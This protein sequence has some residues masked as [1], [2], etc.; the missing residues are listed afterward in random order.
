MDTTHN[1]RNHSAKRPQHRRNGPKRPHQK[2]YQSNYSHNQNHVELDHLDEDQRLD[3]RPPRSR[4]VLQ[5]N[6]DK[7]LNLAR[8]AMSAGDRVLSEHNLQHADHFN[9]LLNEQKDVQKIMD[10][11]RQQSQKDSMQHQR[12]TEKTEPQENITEEPAESLEVQ[13]VDQQNETASDP[14]PQESAPPVAEVAKSAPKPRKR[15]VVKDSTPEDTASV[16]ED[17]QENH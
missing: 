13:S 4:I 10:M 5:Q 16:S 17:P 1:T 3:Y 11:R 9:R 15:K 8:D 2:N 14:I 7:F 6:V 12:H